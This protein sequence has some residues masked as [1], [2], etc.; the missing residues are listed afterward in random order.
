MVSQQYNF[1]PFE[2]LPI[3]IQIEV[4]SYTNLVPQPYQNISSDRVPGIILPLRIK[5]E[6]VPRHQLWKCCSCASYY[7]PCIYTQAEGYRPLRLRLLPS[8]RCGPLDTSLFDVSRT[9][10]YLSRRIYFSENVFRLEGETEACLSQI[11]GEPPKDVRHIRRLNIIMWNHELTC[12]TWQWL[13]LIMRLRG[14]MNTSRLHVKLVTT[15][16]GNGWELG[17]GP[18]ATWKQLNTLRAHLLASKIPQMFKSFQLLALQQVDRVFRPVKLV[19]VL[20]CKCPRTY[21][22]RM[23]WDYRW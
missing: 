16:Y 22:D 1:F 2:A 12:E 19:S 9:I 8:C 11:L 18:I 15:Q 23:R 10:R 13:E 5:D 4:L 3:E 14:L 7:S 17:M 20:D 6:Y 21:I